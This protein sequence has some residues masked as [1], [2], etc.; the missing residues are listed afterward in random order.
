MKNVNKTLSLRV[1]LYIQEFEVDIAQKSKDKNVK[2]NVNSHKSVID[3]LKDF[4]YN[5][6]KDKIEKYYKYQNISAINFMKKEFP[7]LEEY[8]NRYS[9]KNKAFFKVLEHGTNNYLLNTQITIDNQHSNFEETQV[10][11]NASGQGDNVNLD[12]LL[13]IDFMKIFHNNPSQVAIGRA[14]ND[15][16]PI[17]GGEDDGQ[18][19]KYIISYYIILYP[20]KLF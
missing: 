4:Y 18:K 20:I 13:K 14:A 11:A 15:F 10:Y 1:V 16:T 9:Y 12:N 8:G 3:L 17:K 19:G 2:K 7:V 5:H 6:S